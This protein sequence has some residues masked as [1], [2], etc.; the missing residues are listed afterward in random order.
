MKELWKK[1]TRTQEQRGW[2]AAIIACV[3]IALFILWLCPPLFMLGLIAFGPIGVLFGV[4]FL[5]SKWVE[6]G[7]R[8]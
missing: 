6:K 1:Y 7:E 4:V 3:V 8:Y 5:I 2:V